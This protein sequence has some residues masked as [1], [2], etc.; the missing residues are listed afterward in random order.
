MLANLIQLLQRLVNDP[1]I[2]AASTFT[3][4]R[5]ADIAVNRAI[6][7][8]LAAFTA[9]L[10]SNSNWAQMAI[11]HDLGSQIG[12]VLGRSS[13][14]ANQSSP[15]TKVRVIVRK[16][17]NAVGHLFYVPTAFPIL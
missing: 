13:P 15:A 16:P 14:Q 8:N 7:A 4:L 5:M 17:A 6:Q 10:N 3:N 2:P 9:W 12:R 11:E 1:T